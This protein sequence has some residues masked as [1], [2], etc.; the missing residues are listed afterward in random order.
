MACTRYM[1]REVENS[2]VQ[3]TNLES[4]RA[5]QAL[6]TRFYEVLCI[7]LQGAVVVV[8]ATTFATKPRTLTPTPPS[9]L[10]ING[11]EQV[12]WT[13]EHR[14]SLLQQQRPQQFIQAHASHPFPSQSQQYLFPC[15]HPPKD[16]RPLKKIQ[17]KK[18]N[19]SNQRAAPE[20]SPGSKKIQWRMIKSSPTHMYSEPT[21]CQLIRVTLAARQGGRGGGGVPA[22]DSCKLW[23]LRRAGPCRPQGRKEL[24][25]PSSTATCSTQPPFRL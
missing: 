22:S 5:P 6:D 18:K 10:L 9:Y 19:N 21:Q 13:L 24:T 4:I 25:Y 20:N 23:I 11:M 2:Q 12:P 14:S 17:K 3:I 15:S 8:P 7:K 16:S 1:Y